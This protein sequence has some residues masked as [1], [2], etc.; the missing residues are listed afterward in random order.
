M[1]RL[2]PVLLTGCATAPQ[3]VPQAEPPAE[4]LTV[5][6]TCPTALPETGGEPAS[7]TGA[8]IAMV[9]LVGATEDSYLRL[10]EVVAPQEGQRVDVAV[11]RDALGAMFALGNVKDVSVVA[12]PLGDG[13]VVLSYHVTEYGY[14]KKV[15]FEGTKAITPREL[16]EVAPSG[17][18]AS[19]LELARLQRAVSQAYVE[20]GFAS[21]E[22]KVTGTDE[23]VVKVDEGPR[24]MVRSIRFD[25]AKRVQAAELLKA[26]KT[27]VG[28]PF[29]EDRLGEDA[30]QLSQVYYD[31]GM[32][33]VS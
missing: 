32:M 15:S 5:V 16:E 12:Q 24:T 14:V 28:L 1:R 33:N 29:R 6:A 13:R 21:A 22:V 11:V 7:V 31:R 10:H 30:V 18:R 9:C 23:V 27:M 4:P 2:L 8:T 20:Q 26:L 3:P 17:R 25:G 19:P